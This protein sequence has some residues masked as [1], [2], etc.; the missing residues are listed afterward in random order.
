MANSLCLVDELRLARIFFV[1]LIPIVSVLAWRQIVA[2]S[3][4]VIIFAFNG[5]LA[6]T[7]AVVPSIAFGIYSK[8][9][10]TRAAFA[11]SVAALLVFYSMLTFGI[12]KYHTNPM[13]PGTIGVFVGL[14]VFAAV[15]AVDRR[16]TA[17]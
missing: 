1:L 14:A 9:Q 13:I 10:S 12:T 16:P 4:S 8:S 6:F 2:P 7:A 3:L 15:A 5:V 11:S 17:S